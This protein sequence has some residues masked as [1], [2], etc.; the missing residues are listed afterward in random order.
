MEQSFSESA[1][2]KHGHNKK[3]R[4]KRRKKKVVTY[5]R[6]QFPPMILRP[7]RRRH[8]LAVTYFPN[9]NRAEIEANVL[10]NDSSHVRETR[11]ANEKIIKFNIIIKVILFG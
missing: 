4:R 5:L 9:C 10:S 6:R 8:L 11:H 7:H 2:K 1:I 3:R